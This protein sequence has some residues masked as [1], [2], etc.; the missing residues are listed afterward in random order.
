[1]SPTPAQAHPAPRMDLVPQVGQP[2]D[3][4][5]APR[6]SI[7]LAPGAAARLNEIRSAAMRARSGGRADMFEACAMLSR[8]RSRSLRAVSD[9]IARCLPQALG[10]TPVLYRAGCAD[11]SFDEAWLLRLAAAAEREDAD[12]FSFLLRS[13]VVPMHRRNM[14][15]L[16]A[17]LARLSSAA[18]DHGV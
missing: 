14:G 6:P 1:M 7:A 9:G 10:S 16:A 2:R 18:A 15:F 11:L 4:R 13:R 5:H 12:S 3:Q 8:D 17:E